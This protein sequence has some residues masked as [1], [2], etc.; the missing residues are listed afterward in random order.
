[1]ARKYNLKKHKDSKILI[2][3]NIVLFCH[4]FVTDFNATR[5]AVAAGYSKKTARSQGSRLLTRVDVQ[6]YISTLTRKV[7]KKY[8]LTSNR[9]V[10]EMMR[11]A[12]SDLRDV[13]E[14]AGT[15][16]KLKDSK[17]LTDAA[18][19][20]ISEVS[21]SETTKSWNM[22]V[23]MYDKIA[24]L[25][26]LHEHF[27]IKNPNAPIGNN[28]DSTNNNNN[29]NLQDVTPKFNNFTYEELLAL[30]KLSEANTRGT[31][32]NTNPT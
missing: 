17:E 7:T 20:C 10:E 2:A 5:A 24:A 31:K 11:I 1:M 6:E 13:M 30:R 27:T 16:V 15:T 4:E 9:I 25:K 29:G 3:D 28:P 26:F 18:A 19:V 8:E 12:F 23:K 22:K 14:W 32:G 21:I